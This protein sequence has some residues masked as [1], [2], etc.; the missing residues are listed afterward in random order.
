MKRRCRC[1][2]SGRRVDR[3][4]RHERRLG[5]RGL[6]PCRA[7]TARPPGRT[8][9][10][11]S[12]RRAGRTVV[13]VNAGSPVAMPWLEVG[14][15]RC[16]WR[17]SRGG[18]GRVAGGC[19][20]RRRRAAGPPARHVPP[21]ARGHPGVRAPPGPRRRGRV[22][23]APPRRVPRDDTVGRPPLFAFGDGLGYADVTI[24]AARVLD[25]F[26]V[27]VELTNAKPRRRSRRPGLR[28]PRTGTT[29]PAT[30]PTNASS[31][32]P[33]APCLPMRRPP[34]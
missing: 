28:P 19:A 3:D 27:E 33:S 16:S 14:R 17:G 1:R 32:S 30:N 5:E 23:R 13:V 15:G 6:G 9:P 7:R 25:P 12:P 29:A 11:G 34:L 26:T 22:P 10:S 20:V 21:P 24:S 4:R 2:R 18:D 8:D 31:G